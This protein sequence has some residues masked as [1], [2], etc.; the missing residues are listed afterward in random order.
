MY[1]QI[2]LSENSIHTCVR[3]TMAFIELI[4]QFKTKYYLFD[5]ISIIMDDTYS[6]AL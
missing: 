6:M 1:D 5:I 2:F 4:Q 3:Y